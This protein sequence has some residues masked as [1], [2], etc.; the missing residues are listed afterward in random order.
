MVLVVAMATG[1]ARAHQINLTTARIVAGSDG[2]V[3]VEVAA[4]AS[5]IDR[6]AKTGIADDATGLVRQDA[7]AAASAAIIDYVDA[8]AIVLG[9]DGLPCRAGPGSVRP[10]GDGVAARTR[11]T[12]GRVAGRLRYRSTMLLDVAPDARQV[13]LIGTGASTTQDVLDAARTETRLPVSAAPSLL[14]VGQRYIGAGVEYVVLG[15]DR[16]AF[17]VALVL[18][19]RRLRPVAGIIA[20]FVLGHAVTLTLATLDVARVPGTIVGPIVA[21]AVVYAAAENFV[22]RRADGRWREAL[23]VGLVQGF[24]AGVKL[25]LGL[26]NLAAASAL[27]AFHVGVGVAQAAIVCVLLPLLL[28]IDRIAERANTAAKPAG[29]IFRSRAIV[30]YPASALIAGLGAIWFVARLTQ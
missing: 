28:G 27:A 10:D 13:V 26:S 25:D 23:V 30:V 18:W 7:L 8:H 3:D 29:R 20:A 5:D 11:W 9:G 16:V 21:A 15:Y 12:C 22:S 1:V 2:T 19:A 4:K 6:A 14:G 24:A 17:L